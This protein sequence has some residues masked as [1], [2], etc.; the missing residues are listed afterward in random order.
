MYIKSLGDGRGQQGNII[1]LSTPGKAY[2]LPLESMLRVQGV[3]LKTLYITVF[4][5]CAALKKELK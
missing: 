2:P 3:V 4:R 1:S 5:T